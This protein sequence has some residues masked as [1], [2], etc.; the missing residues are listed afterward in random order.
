VGRSRKGSASSTQRRRWPRNLRLFLPSPLSS[1]LI[2]LCFSPSFFPWSLA[3]PWG[4]RRVAKSGK[5]ASSYAAANSVGSRAMDGPHALR[6]ARRS[7]LKRG[8][9]RDLCG[10]DHTSVNAPDPI[11][12]P[13]LSA[14][15]LE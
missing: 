7:P 1:S 8:R 3:P 15:G 2:L 12:T 10:C 13:Q 6:V 9:G 5:R 4:G 14:L 11:R